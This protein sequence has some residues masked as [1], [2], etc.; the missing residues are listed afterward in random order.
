MLKACR[1]RSGFVHARVARFICMLFSLVVLTSVGYSGIDS[2]G[3]VV[4]ICTINIQPT[5]T[6]M[7]SV[8]FETLM[9]KVPYMLDEMVNSQGLRIEFYEHPVHGDGAPVLVV[10]PA[11]RLAFRSDFYETD[12]MAYVGSDYEPQLIGQDCV[13]AFEVN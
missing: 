11:E 13:C 5:G 3:F 1:C 10:F 2:L 8:N 6:M 12:D 7:K 4:N 9:A